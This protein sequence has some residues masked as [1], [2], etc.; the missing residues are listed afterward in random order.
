MDTI[1]HMRPMLRE[2]VAELYNAKADEYLQQGDSTKA[3]DFRAIA[4]D[5]MT[6]VDLDPDR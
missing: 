3:A 6:P 5:W 2:H 1:E 4:Q